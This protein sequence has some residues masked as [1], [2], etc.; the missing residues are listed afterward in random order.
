MF[1]T[2]F[3][4]SERNSRRNKTRG[5]TN[6]AVEVNKCNRTLQFARIN[7]LSLRPS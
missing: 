7:S 3:K 2:D 6:P 1:D 5:V 4:T